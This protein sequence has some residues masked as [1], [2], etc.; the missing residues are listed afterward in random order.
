MKFLAV[1]LIFAAMVTCAPKTRLQYTHC[2]VTPVAT[3]RQLLDCREGKLDVTV[4]K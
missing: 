4:R 1:F 3:D 2:K